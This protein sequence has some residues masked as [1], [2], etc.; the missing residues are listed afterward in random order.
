MITQDAL[1]LFRNALYG[2]SVNLQI[3]YIAVGS[4]SSPIT[5]VET[6]LGNET[7]RTQISTRN[8]TSN[9]VLDTIASAL[10]SDGAMT[11]REIGFFAGGNAVKDSGTLISRILWN[12]DKTSLESIQFNRTDTVGRG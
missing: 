1:N 9:G 12:R 11:I 4:D 8:K 7:F 2:D 3:N 5:G 6:T 10:D